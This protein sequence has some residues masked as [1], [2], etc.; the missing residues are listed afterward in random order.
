MTFWLKD[1]I[2]II[3]AFMSNMFLKLHILVFFSLLGI[4]TPNES[5]E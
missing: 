2:L 3:C 4:T 5:V 1:L